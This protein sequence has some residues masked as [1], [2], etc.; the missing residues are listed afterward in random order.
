MKDYVIV[1]FLN[2]IKQ[3]HQNVESLRGI[4]D[5]R[6]HHLC[7]EFI[8][9]GYIG[10]IDK[11]LRDFRRW[12][13]EKRDRLR[14]R[15]FQRGHFDIHYLCEEFYEFLHEYE[16]RYR[17]EYSRY[18]FDIDFEEGEEISTERLYNSIRNF[19]NGYIYEDLAE[20]LRTRE[21]EIFHLLTI[22]GELEISLFIDW[23]SHNH[24]EIDLLAN[25]P[26]AVLK[27]LVGEFFEEKRE[28][29][30]FA[31]ATPES[32][33]QQLIKMKKGEFYRE[34][35]EKLLERSVRIKKRNRSYIESIDPLDRYR[36]VPL[37]AIFLYSSQHDYI[38]EYIIKN[39]GALSSMSGDYCDIYFSIDQLEYE[40]DAFD[41]IDQIK[42]F[43]GIDIARLPGILFWE[44]DISNNYFLSFKNF[45]E[46]NITQLL[47]IVFQQ[48]RNSQDLKAVKKGEEVFKKDYENKKAIYEIHQP[49]VTINVEQAFG[50]V[51]GSIQGDFIK[52]GINIE[53][54][55]EIFKTLELNKETTERIKSLE[56]TLKYNESAVEE[57]HSLIQELVNKNASNKSFIS[58]LK[59]FAY[60]VSTSVPGSIIANA[61][62]VALMGV[63]R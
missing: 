24:P 42:D 25:I 44:K 51:I 34:L 12:L 60:N 61:I 43:R 16:Q 26:D 32:L 38:Q 5:E 13:Y 58:K 10:P 62:W 29:K 52:S 4:S 2:W 54:L 7:R 21:P 49:T 45:D 37:H 47:F 27:G 15:Y 35:F 30:R 39:W 6:L 56:R 1:D 3:A 19:L 20:H 23:L 36:T 57:V 40:T 46:K 9:K 17:R 28:Y 48:I 55:K 11:I 18:P 33:L 63:Q 41:V 14:Y 22:S 50:E 53:T 8:E 31:T 59:D